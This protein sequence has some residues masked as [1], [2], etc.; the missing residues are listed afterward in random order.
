M[1]SSGS[2]AEPRIV[3][4]VR[5]SACVSSRGSLSVIVG[6][7][8]RIIGAYPIAATQ[9]RN[10]LLDYDARQMKPCLMASAVVVPHDEA[11]E[12]IRPVSK[13]FVCYDAVTALTEHFCQIAEILPVRTRGD[14]FGS[15]SGQ[16][17]THSSASR[18]IG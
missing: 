5:R 14:E 16:D 18:T 17:E 7:F 3:V 8:M 6:H 12:S 13:L 15:A 11:G 2:G 9:Y 1:N 10:V 4:R